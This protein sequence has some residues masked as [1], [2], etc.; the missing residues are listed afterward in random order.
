MFEEIILQQQ[1]MKKVRL[2]LR[3]CLKIG[4]RKVLCGKVDKKVVA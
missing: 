1:S 2:L 4:F 3:S